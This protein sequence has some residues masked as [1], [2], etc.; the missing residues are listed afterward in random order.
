MKKVLTFVTVLALITSLLTVSVSANQSISNGG[1]SLMLDELNH[2]F[3]PK[4]FDEE[5]EKRADE[6]FEQLSWLY[7]NREECIEQYKETPTSAQLSL[8]TQLN[9]SILRYETLIADMGITKLSQSQ[10]S[11]MMEDEADYA[12]NSVVAPSS[13]ANTNYYL[14]GPYEVD[15]IAYDGEE[16]TVTYYYVT[17]LANS[18]NSN[19]YKAVTSHI[20]SDE[21][22]DYMNKLVEIYISKLIGTALSVNKVVEYLPWELLLDAPTSQYSSNANYTIQTNC[23]TNVKFV[24]CYSPTYH[25]YFLGCVLH[26]T[27]ISETHKMAYVE[28]GTMTTKT[29]ENE[30]NQVS[31]NYY[32]PRYA[33]EELWSTTSSKLVERISAID[34]YYEGEK[35]ATVIPPYATSYMDMN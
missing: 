30:Y 15:A 7:I 10:A 18:T 35:V 17:A 34:Y 20:K 3:V 24:W 12:S 21:I 23:M 4:E 28:N 19:M 9:D 2:D 13:T 25:D 31:D 6:I 16:V 1:F 29:H 11:L 26:S 8:I 32:S 22:Q 33:V 5:K 27:S 14:H